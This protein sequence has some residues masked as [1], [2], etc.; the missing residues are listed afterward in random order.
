MSG[1]QQLIVEMRKVRLVIDAA[2]LETLMAHRQTGKALEACGVLLGRQWD[3]L[4]QVTLATPPQKS[5]VRSRTR[6]A[7]MKTGHLTLAKA[8]WKNSKGLI[9]YLGEWHSH[10]EDHAHPSSHDLRSSREIAKRNRSSVLGII[11]GVLGCYAY[12]SDAKGLLCDAR[13]EFTQA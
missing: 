3:D 9:G 2:A 12:L 5:D 10:P 1:M 7:R 13:F 11:V 4:L 8:E 6:Y